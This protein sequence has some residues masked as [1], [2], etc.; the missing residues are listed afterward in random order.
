MSTRFAPRLALIAVVALAAR[1]IYALVIVK[2]DV[3]IGDAREF[4]TL[5]RNLA[6]GHGYVNPY[7]LEQGVRSGPRRSSRRA[8]RSR[9]RG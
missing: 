5:A 1:L 9:W 6:D 7:L 4:D 2:T 3:L 8:T